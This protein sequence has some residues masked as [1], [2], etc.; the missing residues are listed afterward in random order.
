MKEV[1]ENSTDMCGN[2]D[3]DLATCKTIYA[4]HGTLYCSRKCGVQDYKYV[5]GHNAE[6]VFDSVAEEVKP[7][8]IGIIPRCELCGQ[9]DKEAVWTTYGQFCT[10]CVGTHIKEDN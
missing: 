5:Y 6:Y 4:A 2:C 1:D 3:V 8:D 7:L 9:E 10:K